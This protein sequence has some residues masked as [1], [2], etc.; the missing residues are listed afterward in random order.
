MRVIAAVAPAGGERL[1]NRA[2]VA[3][4]LALLVGGGVALADSYGWRQGALLLT[5]A[6]LG[7]VLYHAAFGFTGA[8]RV[9][10][11]E[12]RGAGVRAQ[13]VMLAVASAVFLPVLSQGSLFGTPVGGALAP[14]GTSVVVG[15]F[16]F[17]IGMQL[18]G[19]CASGT[20]FTV[21]GGN[22]R[23]LATLVFFIVGSLIGSLHLP[24]W[25]EAPSFGIVSLPRMFGLWPALVLQLGL[26]A[27]IALATIAWER[28]RRPGMAVESTVAAPT[29]A[30]GGWR[31]LLRGP[32]PLIWG[33]VGLALLN[34]ATLALAGRPWTITFAFS[35][36]GAK[37]A[38]LAGLDVAVWE[39]WTWPFPAQALRASVFADITSVMNFGI[40]LG[41]LLAAALAGRFAPSW[42]GIAWPALVASV[43][44]GLL[45]GYGSRLA[46]GC[47]IGAFFSG[48]ASGSLHGW[49]WFA[50]ALAGNMAGIRLRPI[51]G[52]SRK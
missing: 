29:D 19:G 9:L 10:L 14:V 5:G 24:W 30:P 2:V 4:A 1:P 26:F 27:L 23:M 49:V 35:L 41:A 31:R 34:I 7:L 12:G 33:A 50:A 17:G 21:G 13:M 44:G 48:V 16:L 15:A 25:L 52:F 47:N 11:T 36:W 45:L 40:L 32:W 3:L 51:F 28:R 22:L 42:R 37:I 43:I 6:A 18:G 8:W 38:A 39:F 20:L 46:F